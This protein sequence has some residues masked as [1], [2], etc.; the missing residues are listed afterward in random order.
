MFREYLGAPEKTAE[1]F[2]AEGFYCIGDAGRLVDPER[3]ELGIQF[4]GRVTEDF[5]LSSGTWVSV[6]TLRP[7][8]VSALAPY[9]T[10][11]V[12]CGHDQE[13]IGA[14]IYPGPALR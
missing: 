12:I 14:L 4:D 11:C 3:P 8:L 2:D 6:G 5:K 7:K 10:D 1:A 9:A 13:M